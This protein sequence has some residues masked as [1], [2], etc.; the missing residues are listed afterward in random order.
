MMTSDISQDWLCC[1]ATDLWAETQERRGQPPSGSFRERSPH[2][3]THHHQERY[4]RMLGRALSLSWAQTCSQIGLRDTCQQ[5]WVSPESPLCGCWTHRQTSRRNPTPDAR[6]REIWS[7]MP[8]WAQMQSLKMRPCCDAA[9]NPP[10]PPPS[11]TRVQSDV[12]P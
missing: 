4:A 7:Q 3:R 5:S 12:Q 2:R 11:T 9:P 6:T 10:R 8:L 1:D